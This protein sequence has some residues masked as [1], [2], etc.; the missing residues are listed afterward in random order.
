MG[1]QQQALAQNSIKQADHEAAEE[2]HK[3]Q[4]SANDVKIA[5][6]EQVSK[7]QDEMDHK[8]KMVRMTSETNQYI[9]SNN[10]K[11]Q[12]LDHNATY[13]DANLRHN[14][15]QASIEH[16][17]R[18]KQEAEHDLNSFKTSQA[19]TTKLSA[20]LEE[21]YAPPSSGVVVTNKI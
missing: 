21:L 16:H 13:H 12:I 8:M 1:A 18:K 11:I 20:E 2:R 15:L 4:K 6:E 5:Q 19:Q 14:T 9:A 3:A 10:A 17:M 7:V